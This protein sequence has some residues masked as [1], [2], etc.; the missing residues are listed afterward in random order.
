MKKSEPTYTI[1]DGGGID[2][3]GLTYDEAVSRFK[4]LSDANEFDA[5]DGDGIADGDEELFTVRLVK[6][7]KKAG[8]VIRG[9][10]WKWEEEK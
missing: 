6:E 3:C 2:S 10:G 1:I 5:E 8:P 9:N 4:T 7:I